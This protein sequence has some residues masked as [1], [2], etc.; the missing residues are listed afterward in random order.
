[1]LNTN[2]PF[3]LASQSEQVL[4]LND[5]VD[6]DWLIVVK[7]NPRDLFNM[8]EFEREVSLNDEVY[9]QDEVEVILCGNNLETDIE[10]SLHMDDV[11]A[12]TVLKTNAQ[13]NE[14]DGF[15]NDNDTGFSANEKSEE[16]FLDDNDGEDS[17]IS[18]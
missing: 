8:P 13:V 12:E 3:V 6:K 7:T 2:E 11:E 9:Q 1:M 14:E 17:D 18:C 10:M 16:E 15:I 4:Y 5:L